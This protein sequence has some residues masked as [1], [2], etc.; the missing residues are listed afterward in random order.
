MRE[1]VSTRERP[2]PPIERVTRVSDRS[3][4]KNTFLHKKAQEVELENVNRSTINNRWS[5][6]SRGRYARWG[7]AE[8][9]EEDYPGRQGMEVEQKFNVQI[10]PAG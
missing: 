1:V 8:D 4:E 2:L 5:V 7:G 6:G 10:G 3:I 9:Q